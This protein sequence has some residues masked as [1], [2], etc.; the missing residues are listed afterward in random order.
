MTPATP[1]FSRLRWPAVWVAVLLFPG[2]LPGATLSDPQVDSYNLRIGTQTFSGLYQFTTNNQLVETANAITN[3]GS[4][5]IKMYLG[6]NFPGKYNTNLPPSVTSLMTLAKNEPNCRHVLDMP[7][8]HYIAWAYPLSNPDAPFQ[9][10]S[11]T[12]TEQAND[13]REMYDLTHYLLTNYNNSGKTFYLGHW[14]GDGY[15]S[16]NNWSTNPAPYTVTNM[17]LWEN[18]RQKGVDDAKSAS[19]YSNVN[20]FYYAE[21]NRVR[22]AMNNGT[23][24]NVRAINYVIPYVTNLDFVSY[25]SYDAMNYDTATVYSMLDYIEAKIPTNKAAV[26][27]PER[28]WIGEYGWGSY[29]TAAQE[30]LT[31]AYIQRLLNYG[32]QAFPFILFW[33][34][35]NNEPNKLFCLIDSNNVKTASYYLHQNFYNK[36]RLSVG[37]Y[38]ESNGRLPTASEFVSL[39]SSNLN[40]PLP[41]PVPLSI[42]HAG[43]PALLSASS[44]RV[45]GT[46]TQGLYGDDCATVW[47]Y[48][49]RQDGGTLRSAWEQSQRVALNTNFNALTF[50]AVL[51]NLTVSTSYAFRFY[52]TNASGE[53]WAPAASQF[54]TPTLVPSDFAC[55]LK[56]TFGG[57][58]RP[59][60]LSNFPVLVNLSTNLAGFSYQQFASAAGGDLRFADASGVWAIPFEID[61]WNPNGT[62]TVWVSVPQLSGP[63]DCIW[64]YWGN[65]AATNPPV[66]STN[67]AVWAPNFYTVYHLKESGFPYLDSAQQHPALSGAALSAVTGKIGRGAAFTGSQYLDAGVISLGNAFTLSAWVNIAPAAFDIQTIWA[68][69]KGGYASAG[70]AWF[71]NTFKTNNQVIDFSSGDGTSGHEATTPYGTVSFGQWHLLAVSVN[72]TAGTVEFYLDGADLQSGTVIPGFANQADVNLGRFTNS[73][74]YFNGSMDEAR[75]ASGIRSSNWVWASWMT[76]ASNP[77]FA[78]YSAVTQQS[79]SLSIAGGQSGLSLTWPTPGVG[80]SLYSATNLAPPVSWRRA[81]NQPML[82]N[83]Q[84][85]VTLPANTHAAQF[86]RLQSQ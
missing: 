8:R 61:E 19:A 80:F 39:V 1:L 32:R 9:N 30:P 43:I 27:P 67:G 77:A 34:M 10:V 28:L 7:F 6:A 69:Q 84:W 14:E 72:R 26:L 16:V 44:A 79:P 24:N 15:L 83:T 62:S 70:F 4:D 63:T 33:E 56:L 51:S 65:P 21:V 71:V 78:S 60:T 66:T 73:S 54:L 81:T 37:R 2:L 68:N 12:A 75:I 46:L 85:E 52:A 59:E 36:A 64:A 41:A 20:V 35:Y 40:Q 38:Q 49:G 82:V 18:T 3:M 5:T 50:S 17:V 53:V 47:V 29:S 25:S 13:Y 42:V 11:Y 31:R 45:L 48:Y 74:F 57:Y 86:Y 22:D 55:S 23:N 76:V 58:T